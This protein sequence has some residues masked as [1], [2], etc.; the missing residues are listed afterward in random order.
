MKTEPDVRFQQD[1]LAE[2]ARMECPLHVAMEEIAQVAVRQHVLYVEGEC[3][4]RPE[5]V[6]RLER[7]LALHARIRSAICA[8]S[9]SGAISV[10][11]LERTLDALL[12]PP[13]D[14]DALPQWRRLRRAL[15]AC[16]TSATC[17]L[18]MDAADAS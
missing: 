1:G 13:G 5:L 2:I 18:G 9:R 7:W 16:A 8:A 11:D 4:P 12:P 10:D 15:T 6:N 17:P 3:Q 14:V